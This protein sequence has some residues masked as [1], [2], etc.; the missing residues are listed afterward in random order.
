MD[1]PHRFPESGRS[2]ANEEAGTMESRPPD[3]HQ[4]SYDP[5]GTIAIFLMVFLVLLLAG[6]VFALVQAA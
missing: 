2:P 1:T 4:V 6:A 3:S 5:H